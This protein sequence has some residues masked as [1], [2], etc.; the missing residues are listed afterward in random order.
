ML[1]FSP[2]VSINPEEISEYLAFGKRVAVEAGKAGGE[3]RVVRRHF[4]GR[5]V[6]RVGD[7]S[8]NFVAGLSH[9][10]L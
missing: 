2:A 1:S 4:A 9:L 7:H 8:T 5:A 10:L 6:P 3:A